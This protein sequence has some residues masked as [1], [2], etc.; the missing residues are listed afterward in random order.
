MSPNE[1]ARAMKLFYTDTLL[2]MWP[3][4]LNSDIVW[5]KREPLQALLTM[6]LCI[7]YDGTLSTNESARAIKSFYTNVLYSLWASTLTYDLRFITIW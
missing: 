5:F 2:S 7:E 3:W 6:N 1:S 4:S